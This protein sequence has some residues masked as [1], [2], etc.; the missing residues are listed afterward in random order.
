MPLFKLGFPLLAASIAALTVAVLSADFSESAWRYYR[1]VL[2]PN[3][4]ADISLVELVPELGVFHYASP[5]LADLRI[6]EVVSQSETQFKLL[7]ERGEHRRTSISA[8]MLDLSYKAGETTSFVLDLEQEGL[9]HSEIEVRTTSKNFQRDVVVEG[10]L[11]GL[12]WRVLKTDGRIFDFTIDEAGE[13]QGFSARDTRINY[14]ASTVRYLKVTIDEPGQDLIAIDGAQVFFA[15]QFAPKRTSLP[16]EILSREEDTE[17]NQTSLVLDL[18]SSGF[19]ANQLILTTEQENFHRRV[20]LEASSDSVNWRPVSRLATIFSF[21]TPLFVGSDLSISFPESPSRYY[22]LTIVNEDNPPLSIGSVEASGYLRK[23][24]F[25]AQSGG[26]YR[27]Y[28]GNSTTRAPSYEIEQ[29][30]PYLITDD[31][32]AVTLGPHTANPEFALPPEPQKPFTERQPWLI[33]TVVG[34]AALVIGAFLTS[35][36]RQVRTILPPPEKD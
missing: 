32:P 22:R 18:G 9:L 12:N 31:L 28:Y 2:L 14:P 17:R 19:P 8:K 30:F 23:L 16:A 3:A 27:L 20:I 34:I 36:L 24:I 25:S 10:S 4:L 33:P 35:L 26:D 29:L 5:G 15:Q 21:N 11:D 7:V 13:D 1:P 6:I